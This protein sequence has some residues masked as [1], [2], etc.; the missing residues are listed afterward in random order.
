LTT[1]TKQSQSYAQNITYTIIVTTL[2]AAAIICVPVFVINRGI[3][4]RHLAIQRAL[5]NEVE[6]RTGQLQFAN[7][8]LLIANEKL[9][10]HDK[11]S[12]Q[13]FAEIKR[14]L[15]VNIAGWKVK[16]I[17]NIIY[18]KTGVRYHEVHIYRLLHRWGFSPKVPRKRFVN[19]VSNNEKKQFKKSK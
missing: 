13:K 5:Q 2:V 18:E 9:M 16:E 19:T 10:L 4:K 17:M 7:N 6:K 11:I 3:H 1:Y 14:E 15:F 8:Q 12:V